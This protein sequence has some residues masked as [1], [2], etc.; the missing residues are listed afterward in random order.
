MFLGASDVTAKYLSASLALDRDRL[1]PLPGVRA[2][3]VA[4]DAAGLAALCDADRP[5]RP[6]TDARRRAAGLVA[7]LHHRSALPADRGSL[8]HR[9]RRAAVRHRAVDHLP[10]REGRHA[11]LDRDRDRPDRRADHPA[12]GHRRVSSRRLLPAR[13]GVGLGLHADHDAHDERQRARHHHHDLF[14]DRGRCD[15]VGAGAVRLGRADLARRSC[16][17]S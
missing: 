15:S 6:A 5:A 17:A 10:R 16:S 14:V 9:L 8:R 13:L 4:G 2:D 7:V 12:A 3:H 11:P 1:D